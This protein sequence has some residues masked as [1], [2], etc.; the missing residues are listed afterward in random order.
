MQCHER[1]NRSNFSPN[2]S[3]KPIHVM[4]EADGKS[5]DKTIEEKRPIFDIF[6][7]FFHKPQFRC[8][9]P[10]SQEVEKRNK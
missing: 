2:N 8:C 1:Q 9:H 4:N 3:K 10:F 5:N 7:K 6:L